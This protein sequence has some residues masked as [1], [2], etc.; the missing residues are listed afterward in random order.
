M[1]NFNSTQVKTN[2]K[3]HSIIVTVPHGGCSLKETSEYIRDCD[4]RAYEAGKLMVNALKTQI[5]KNRVR[6]LGAIDV[7]FFPN[8]S[9]YRQ[10]ADLNRFSA[11]WTDWTNELHKVTRSENPA[12]II[13]MHSFPSN[14]TWNRGEQAKLVFLDLFHYSLGERAQL[15]FITKLSP[16]K[17][18]IEASDDN[19]I[20][21]R[22]REKGIK[23][24]LIEVNE[25]PSV[26]PTNEL[27]TDISRIAQTIV[28]NL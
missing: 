27:I 12:W 9:V 20:M 14:Y 2:G 25:N 23:S 19:A 5:E 6:G 3:H 18:W 15:E 16:Q 28:E 24:I 13:D 7:I 26:Y 21:V 11:D 10:D 4:L 8:L 1:G 22:A 17:L